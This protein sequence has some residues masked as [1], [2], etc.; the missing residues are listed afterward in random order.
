MGA[1]RG[2]DATADFC[3][4]RQRC[5]PGF[6]LWIDIQSRKHNSESAASR[7]A[8]TEM[9]FQSEEMTA[10]QDFSRQRGHVLN[11]EI[12][13]PGRGENFSHARMCHTRQSVLWKISQGEYFSCRCD[14]PGVTCGKISEPSRWISATALARRRAWAALQ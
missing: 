4:T 7:L 11:F 8:K 9:I 6:L 2:G 14:N 12:P 10:T 3:K 13:H 5:A 1:G